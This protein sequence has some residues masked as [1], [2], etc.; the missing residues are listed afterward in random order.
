MKGDDVS[1]EVVLAFKPPSKQ[2][3]FVLVTS[4]RLFAEIHKSLLLTS[5]NRHLKK[6]KHDTCAMYFCV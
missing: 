1:T 2:S 3:I 5:P 6:V 4:L